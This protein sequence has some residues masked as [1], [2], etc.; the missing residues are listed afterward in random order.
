MG[1]YTP[2]TALK[3]PST[4]KQRRYLVGVNMSHAGAFTSMFNDSAK[5]GPKLE[6]G[7]VGAVWG[8]PRGD[9]DALAAMHGTLKVVNHATEMVGYVDGALML[10]DTDHGTTHAALARPLVEAGLPTFVNQPMM[11]A[12]PDAV[13][14]FDPADRR[15]ALLMSSS[16]LRFADEV[17]DVKRQLTEI[18]QLSTI[19]SVGPGR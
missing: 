19:V 1:G 12:I 8:E 14:T 9:V 17:V 4:G 2:L 7:R 10:D 15:G 16:A 13:E 5:D 11:L 6:G 3:P 18:G